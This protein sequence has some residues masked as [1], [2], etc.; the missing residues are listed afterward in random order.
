MN[1]TQVSRLFAELSQAADTL[2][3]ESNHINQLIQ[4]FEE[5]LRQT[6]VGLEVWCGAFL[7]SS[8]VDIVSPDG[9]TSEPG[10]EETHL[11]WAKGFKGWE[12]MVSVWE[13]QQQD[14]EWEHTRTHSVEPLRQA[15]RDLRIKALEHFPDL[16]ERLTSE[17]EK[18]I[19]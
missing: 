10:C 8:P 15:S 2:N 7:T 12:L 13:F 4:R 3:T 9:E 18:A 14:G 11:G 6:N 1:D 17:A 5:R 19:R 16:L